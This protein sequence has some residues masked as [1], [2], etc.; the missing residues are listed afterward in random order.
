MCYVTLE[1]DFADAIKLRTLRQGDYPR[2]S[3]WA[4][5]NHMGPSKWKRD[6][7][8]EVRV[9]WCKD[10]ALFTVFEGGRNH[11]PRNAG[12]LKENG[13]GK[14]TFSPSAARKGHSPA[15]TLNLAHW[16]MCQTSDIQN[17]NI[18]ILCCFKPLS[19]CL[20]L[21]HQIDEYRN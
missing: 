7:I 19:V 4:Q 2:L 17:Y 12:G 1:K 11:E 5:C 14:E 18:I 8:E 15:G 20:L 21:Q 10:L 16:D 6:V 9:I 13:K 3:V